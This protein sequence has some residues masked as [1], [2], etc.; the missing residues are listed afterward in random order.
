MERISLASRIDVARKL[1]LEQISTA[2]F[3]GAYV[4]KQHRAFRGVLFAQ[5]GAGTSDRLTSDC[6]GDGGCAVPIVDLPWG[7][8]GRQGGQG[9]HQGGC[10]QSGQGR[11]TRKSKWP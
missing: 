7:V 8:D 9:D 5:A 4:L 3:F 2:D 1:S 10:R 11:Q 6:V